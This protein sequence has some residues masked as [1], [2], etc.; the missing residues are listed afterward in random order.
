MGYVLELHALSAA[1]LATELG[2]GAGDVTDEQA[3]HVVSVI[4]RL[5]A[6]VGSVDHGSSGGEWFRDEFMGGLVASAIG[7]DAAAH[8]LDR[9]FEGHVWGVRP[10]VGWLSHAELKEVATRLG[11]RGA[12]SFDAPDRDQA[13][14]LDTI[15]FAIRAT[16]DNGRDIVTVYT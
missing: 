16:A 13:D 7:A 8:L 5:G 10:T 3:N 15:L 2:P 14:L 11:D 12:D 1:D 9:P 6:L 4:R